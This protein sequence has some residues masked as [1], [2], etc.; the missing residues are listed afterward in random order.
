MAV[1]PVGTPIVVHFTGF[2]YLIDVPGQILATQASIP[3]DTLGD[4]PAIT[5]A[6][7]AHVVVATVSGGCL[8]PLM[9]ND[10]SQGTAPN[11]FQTL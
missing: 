7:H 8:T 3:A 6:D 10:I 1:P 11:Q 5:D 2:G 9:L 4:M